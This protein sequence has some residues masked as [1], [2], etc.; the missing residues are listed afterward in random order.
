MLGGSIDWT[1]LSSLCLC[2]YVQEDDLLALALNGRS[3]HQEVPLLCQ[4]PPPSLKGNVKSVHDPPPVIR[5]ESYLD[6]A[7]QHAAQG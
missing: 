2:R 7:S 1:S 3:R 5:D 6:R 4:K